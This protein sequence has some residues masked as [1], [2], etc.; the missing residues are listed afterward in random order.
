MKIFKKIILPGFVA[1]IFMAIASVVL[2]YLGNMIFPSLAIE[3]ANTDV[4]RAMNDPLMIAFWFTPL[5]TGLILAFVWDNTKKL[6]KGH[7]FCRGRKFGVM[8]FLVVTFPGMFITYTSMQVS[9]LMV[10]SWAV[11]GLIHGLIAGWTFVWLN[12]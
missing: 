7:S 4:F 10:G 6:F 9:F 11:M 1:A 3:Y 8:Y 2:S 12:K 5:I